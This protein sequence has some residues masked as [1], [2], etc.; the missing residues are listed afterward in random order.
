MYFHYFFRHSFVKP[1]QIKM[2]CA[3]AI[4]LKN[5]KN[6]IFI[7]KVRVFVCGGYIFPQWGGGSGGW[8]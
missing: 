7:Q 6:V 8:P 1:N 4:L 2:P 3:Y 5:V